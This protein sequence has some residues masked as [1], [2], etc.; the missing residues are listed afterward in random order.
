VIDIDSVKGLPLLEGIEATYL[1]TLADQMQLR[2]YV[3]K[4]V[5]LRKGDVANEFLFLISGQLQVVDVSI[6]GKD[7][8]LYLIHP[9]EAFGHMAL[10]DEQPRSSSVI[11]TQVAEVVSMSKASAIK[12]FYD[13]PVVMHRLL[14]EFARIIRNT[15]TARTVLSQTNATSRV[16]SVLMNLMQPNV[17]GLM[18]IEKLPRQQELAIMANTSRET[19]SRAISLLISKEIVEKDMRRLI[20]RKPD[21]LIHMSDDSEE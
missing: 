3:S 15:N 1:Q 20:V 12:L 8:G 9:G 10:L 6:D 14:V 5:V 21:E 4:Q 17:A 13:Y 16:C 2:H 11:A 19:I 7:V 18:T